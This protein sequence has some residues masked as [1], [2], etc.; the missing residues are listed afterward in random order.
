MRFAPHAGLFFIA[1]GHLFWMLGGI[2]WLVGH[3]YMECYKEESYEHLEG[4]A[5]SCLFS[6]KLTYWFW[7]FLLWLI[8]N[9]LF[10]YVTRPNLTVVP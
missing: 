9:C 3:D 8:G 10:A 4:E 7:T 2:V 6:K 5:C 1:M